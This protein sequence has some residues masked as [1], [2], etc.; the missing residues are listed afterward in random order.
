MFGGTYLNAGSFS[1][2][3]KSSMSIQPRSTGDDDIYIQLVTYPGM[4]VGNMLILQTLI[5]VLFNLL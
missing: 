5:R 4:Q 3:N 1:V 2:V